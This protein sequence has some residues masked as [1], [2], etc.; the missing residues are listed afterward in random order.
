MGQML[1][2]STRFCLSGSR[3]A[4]VTRKPFR[5]QREKARR[6]P[7][8]GAFVP[9]PQMF[10]R[11]R[12]HSA[13]VFTEADLATSGEREQ[14]WVRS[15]WREHVGNWVALDRGR[16]I[17]EAT[18]AREALEKARAAGVLSPFLVHVTEPSELPFGGW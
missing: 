18:H 12:T 8:W 2:H 17:A 4:Q 7:A 6:L 3:L 14:E 10:R 9:M 1:A 11:R 15:H 16:L 5:R 13:T